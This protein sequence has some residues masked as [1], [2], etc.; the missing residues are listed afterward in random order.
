M[1]IWE[2]T[3]CATGPCHK[4]YLSFYGSKPELCKYEFVKCSWLLKEVKE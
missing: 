3:D 2:C 4:T 1:E